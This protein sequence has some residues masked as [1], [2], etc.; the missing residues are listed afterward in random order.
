M[1]T[2]AKTLGLVLLIVGLSA[3]LAVPAHAEM[4]GTAEVLAGQTGQADRDTLKQ[5][6]ERSDVEERLQAMDVPAATARS[7]VD[8][9]TPAEAATLAQRID[10]LPAGG[11]LSG[12]DVIIILLVAILVVLIL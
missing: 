7:R 12:N 3:A 6:L 8:A 10:S 11:A 4:I 5:F 1:K 9:L 2:P